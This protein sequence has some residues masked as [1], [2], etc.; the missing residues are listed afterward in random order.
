MVE[1]ESEILI[2]N[3][4]NENSSKIIQDSRIKISL[5]EHQKT[6]IKAMIDFEDRGIVKFTREAA[7]QHFNIVDKEERENS[8]YYNY[9]NRYNQNIEYKNTE[10]NDRNLYIPIKTI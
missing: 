10:K 4:L 9:Y 6:A 8:W 7:I 2:Y 5:K 3:N 1:T